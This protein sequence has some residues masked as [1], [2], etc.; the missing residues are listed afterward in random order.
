MDQQ[1]TAVL[2]AISTSMA[3]IPAGTITLRD[4]RIQR[5]WEVELPSFL[6]SRF[7]VTQEWYTAL[8]GISPSAIKGDQLPVESVSW[9]DAVTFCNRLS[10][11]T[12]LDSCYSV[13]E[14]G[15]TIVFHPEANGYRLPTED[16]WEYACRAGTT[17][18]HYGELDD[19]A[20][21]KANSEGTTHAVG[22]KQ[23]NAFGLYDMLGNVWEWCSDIYDEQVYGSYR[24]FRGGGWFD[25]TRGCMATNRRRS[26]PV[27]FKIDD[28]G[29]RV[30]RNG[31]V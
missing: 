16:E 2:S 23:P 26:H 30:A 21:Y 20:W 15:E 22:T 10:E 7:P 19:I 31:K 8:T 28:L 24:I 18:I 27:S 14:D 4:D 12:G 5:K 6:L 25:D 29:F 13:G 11:Q 3:S 17:G 1:L 9:K